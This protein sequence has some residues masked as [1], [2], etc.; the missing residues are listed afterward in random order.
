MSGPAEFGP[1]IVYE[2]LG[3]GAMASVHRAETRGAAGFRKAIALKRLHPQLVAN[4]ELVQAFVYEARLASHLKHGNIVQTFDFGKVDD[5]YFIAMELARGPTLKQVIRQCVSAAGAMPLPIAIGVIIQICDALDHAH[6]LT[7]DTGK[8]LGIVHRDVSPSNVI[9]DSSGIVKLIDF[10][11]AKVKSRN[12]QT[13]A[14][15]IKGKFGYIAPE[16]LAGQIDHR[17]DLFAVGVLTHE[18]LTSRQLFT[19]QNE[20]ETLSKVREMP[21][22]PPSRWNP[23][24]PTELDHIVLTALQRDPSLRWQNAGALRNALMG[25]L[26]EA[27]EVVTDKRVAD[28][29]MWAFSQKP[30]NDDSAMVRLIDDLEPSVS[31]EIV[32]DADASVEPRITPEGKT[33]V[34]AAKEA[35]EASQAPT[36]PAPIV[37]FVPARST[38]A[39]EGTVE[40]VPASKPSDGDP[41]ALFPGLR[42]A[43][44]DSHQPIPMGPMPTRPERSGT[45]DPGGE[46]PVLGSASARLAAE[47]A[48]SR[49]TEPPEEP[50]IP[51]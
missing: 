12:V 18:L 15:T 26:K 51:S 41:L 23:Q 10:G 37:E 13:Q 28:W 17:A 11:I 46:R 44:R 7:D 22:Q 8:P 1:Y 6:N 48:A 49:M 25:V 16:Y 27:N 3:S 2:E 19:A 34:L 47:D 45:K 4:E 35:V 24:V 20:W 50:T 40:L 31:V 21:I 30:R 14:G 5:T 36:T 29:V 9:I 38:P 42:R 43:N 32:K 39:F 33:V